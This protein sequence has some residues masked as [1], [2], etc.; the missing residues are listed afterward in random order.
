[1]TSLRVPELKALLKAHGL[2]SAGLKQDLLDRCQQQIPDHLGALERGQTTGLPAPKR[3]QLSHASPP[4]T[5]QQQQQQHDL[6]IQQELTRV[7][8]KEAEDKAKCVQVYCELSGGGEG[9]E[10]DGLTLCEKLDI[11]P[12][13]LSALAVSYFLGSKVLGQFPQ[14]A[15]VQRLWELRV[16]SLPDLKSRVAK[17]ERAVRFEDGKE[18]DA[19]YAFAFQWGIKLSKEEKIEL[20]QVL[21]PNFALMDSWVRY[22]KRPELGKIGKDD[23]KS[24]PRL[25]R[26]A[27][28]KALPELDE[29][30]WPSAYLG[31]AEWTRSHQ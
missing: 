29:E 22:W 30:S 21:V 28:G 18:F 1:M 6:K 9:A 24:F 16:F 7:N 11:N 3:Q 27:K 26:L 20:W 31:F 23:W 25:V 4:H 17:W 15:M 13:S 14:S 12:E 10:L 8:S 5:Q 19:V 2:S